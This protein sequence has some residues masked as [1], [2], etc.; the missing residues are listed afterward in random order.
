MIVVGT[1]ITA[2]AMNNPDIWSSWMRN[3][4]KVKEEYQKF[5]TFSD[6]KYFA[7]IEVDARGLEPFAP[8][9]ERLQ[10]IGGEY[11]TYSLDDGRTEITT[12]NRLRHITFGQ[13]L[14]VDY[15]QANPAVTHLLFMAADCMPPDDVMPR[16]L[17]MDHPLVAPY[18]TTYALRGP[19]VEKYPYPVMDTMASA[20]CIFIAR[21]VFRAIR[22]RW[23]LDTNLSDD[24]AYHHDAL[25][26]LGIPTY[27]REDSIAKHFP[28][29]IGSIETRGYDMTVARQ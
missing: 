11:F 27:V 1:T 7:A 25:H 3:A 18:I 19:K 2:F 21:S 5:G 17:E 14:V 13:N 28:E 23:D 4:E 24:P 22:W 16:M 8:F 6:I 10:A 29:S 12:L 15:C 26:L 20:A 9:I